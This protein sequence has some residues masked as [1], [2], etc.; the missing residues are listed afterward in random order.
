M[1]KCLHVPVLHDCNK[2]MKIS[3]HQYAQALFSS[4]NEDEVLDIKSKL[5][6]SQQTK[7]ILTN[8][9]ISASDKIGFLKELKFGD[10]LINFLFILDKNKDLN[11]LE[12]I[13]QKFNQLYLD[14]NGLLEVEITSFDNLDDEQIKNIKN[15]LE[16]KFGKKILIS[17]SIDKNLLGGLVITAKD[18]V[19]DLS[20]KNKLEQL[21]T[22]LIR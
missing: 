11:Q 8:P 14:Q 1:F 18:Y 4:L 20:L 12:K 19:I 3:S 7:K 5:I 13:Y 6:Q 9:Q 17:N 22:E 21:K 10:K 15:N 16:K 2:P